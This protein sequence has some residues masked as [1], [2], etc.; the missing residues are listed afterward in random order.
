MGPLVKAGQFYKSDSSN[1]YLRI[2]SVHEDTSGESVGYAKILNRWG[3]FIDI[4][5][6]SFESKELI[7]KHDVPFDIGRLMDTLVRYYQS[8][9]RQDKEVVELTQEIRKL[10]QEVR[11][12]KY[13][14]VQILETD[15]WTSTGDV[16]SYSLSDFVLENIHGGDADTIRAIG[17]ASATV[18]EVMEDQSPAIGCVWFKENEEGKLKK[19]KYNYDSSG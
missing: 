7:P 9:N 15:Q 10:K 4:S 8:H 11:S 6:V 16:E 2:V 17:I 12:L 19:W 18:R 1:S 3:N 13:A 5:L 14:K